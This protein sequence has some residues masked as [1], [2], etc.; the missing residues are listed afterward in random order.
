MTPRASTAPWLRPVALAIGLVVL[1]VAA[2]QVAGLVFCGLTGA[3]K[4]LDV[5]PL[6]FYQ[7]WYWYRS[8]PTWQ[9]YVWGSGAAGVLSAGR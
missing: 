1:L 5:T 6:T 2:L 9:S 4:P 7:Y 3:A 8:H